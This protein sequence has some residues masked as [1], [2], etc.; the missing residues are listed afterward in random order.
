M[1]KSCK[2]ELCYD[3]QVHQSHSVAVGLVTGRASGMSMFRHNN[4]QE[5]TFGDLPNRE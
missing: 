1:Y 4:S 2:T 3:L 5:F